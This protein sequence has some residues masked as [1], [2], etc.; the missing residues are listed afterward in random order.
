MSANNIKT[1]S[2][3][4]IQKLKKVNVDAIEF[5]DVSTNQYGGKFVNI[6]FDGA[7]KL[8]LP[9][10]P[11]YGIQ[12]Y[13]DQNS[14]K[15]NFTITLKF[16]RED[17]ETNKEVKQTFDKLL[18]IQTKIKELLK[19]RSQEFFK[20]KNASKDFIDA[21]FTDFIKESKN[22]ETDEPDGRYYNIKIKVTQSKDKETGELKDNFICKFYNDK[23]EKL[24]DSNGEEITSKNSAE[25]GFGS[26]ALCTIMPGSL[27]FMAGN[28]A[29]VSWNLHQAVVKPVGPYK[30]ND[31]CQLVESSEE[32]DD[33]SD[34]SDDESDD[35]TK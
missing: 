13:E 10:L 23:K 30:G 22:K 7:N 12:C 24:V 15:K 17:L 3:G 21:C 33:T 4:G 20:K 16:S 26:E 28:K 25:I 6:N 31:T 14:G 32:G 34:G 35:D 5:G 9:N 29:G 27:W 11:T 18:E 1:M 2:K 8:Q 19:D